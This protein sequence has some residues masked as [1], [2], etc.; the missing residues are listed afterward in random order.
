MRLKNEIADYIDRD[1]NNF[2]LVIE[3]LYEAVKAGKIAIRNSE[4]V[5]PVASKKRGYRTVE[6]P[7]AIYESLSDTL[8]IDEI[9]VEDFLK[10]VTDAVDEGLI[11][12]ENGKIVVE[13]AQ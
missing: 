12:L 5:I 2:R 6:L 1:S 9:S 3:S 8:A 11:W 13:N 7:D 10:A 4:V